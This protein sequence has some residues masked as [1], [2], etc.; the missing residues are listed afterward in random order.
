MTRFFQAAILRE[1]N[2]P[3]SFEF[4]ACEPL[5]S[6]QVLIKVD[7]IGVCGS[8]LLEIRGEK[9]NSGFLPHLLG[10]E[11]A[12]TVISTGPGVTKVA[13]GD[14]VVIHWRPSSGLEGGLSHVKT[15]QGEIIKGGP[16]TTFA[17][18]S[19]VGEN[20]IT[21]VSSSL[22]A[23]LAALLGCSLS[24]GMG[25]VN[26]E[27]NFRAGSSALVIGAGGVGLSI[28]LALSLRSPG[29]V[30]IVDKDQTKEALSKSL[31]VS[32]FFSNFE[33]LETVSSQAEVGFDFVFEASG[34][35][36]GR[37]EAA[38]LVKSNGTVIFIGQRGSNALFDLG[39]ES[40]LF[41]P[42]G[43]NVRF[44]QGGSFSPERDIPQWSRSLQSHSTKFS[45]LAAVT[46]GD[47]TV[48][49]SLL[50]NLEKGAP[51]RQVLVLV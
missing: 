6:G 48:L 41:K 8:Q 2:K 17:E 24:T 25:V 15:K 16:A 11:G 3:L 43:L 37:T 47:L 49:N 32:H 10:H 13:K 51:G 22:P 38:K 34:S 5:R 28:A 44:S 33:E 18:Y 4:V 30:W 9:G 45:K 27:I 46:H 31:G 14:N 39:P 21:P 35:E 42:E 36:R 26:N 20:R 29:V 40:V 23:T 19:V 7:A 1:L 12:G 50:Q